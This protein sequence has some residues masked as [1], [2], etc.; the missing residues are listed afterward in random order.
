MVR[1]TLEIP[2]YRTKSV[3]LITTLLD[4]KLFPA[5]ELAQLYARRWR[6]ELWF[7]D[8]KTSMG[9]EVLRCL[10]PKM[11]HKELE[12]FFIAYNM[13]RCLMADAAKIHD[14]PIDRLSFKGTVD[15]VRQFSVAIA[16]AR[17]QNMRKELVA[18]LLELIAQDQVPDRPGRREPRAVKRRPK[19]YQKLSRPRHMMKEMQHRSKY[20]KNR[21][22]I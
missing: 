9:M 5:A 11:V 17:S 19:P 12:M 20:R 2:G 6:I 18:R 1:F 10:S 22:L 3:T 14:A 8:I 16:Q 13:I 7:R 21:A 4:P 15:S